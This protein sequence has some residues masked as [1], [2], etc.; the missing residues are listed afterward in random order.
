MANFLDNCPFVVNPT[1]EDHDDDLVGDAC[2]NCKN[3]SNHNQEDKNNN[4]V[5]DTCDDEYDQDNDGIPDDQLEAIDDML[6]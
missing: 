6:M 1:Q 2:D 3:V 4:L 5:G